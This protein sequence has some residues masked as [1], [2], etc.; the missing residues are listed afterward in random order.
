VSGARYYEF[1]IIDDAA[2]A[3]AFA[4]CAGISIASATF[5]HFVLGADTIDSA[6]VMGFSTAVVLAMFVAKYARAPRQVKEAANLQFR[7]RELIKL[8]LASI[9]ES[10][11]ALLIISV[12][13]KTS[14]AISY[15][16]TALDQV[17]SGQ[18]VSSYKIEIAKQTI[19][20]AL[21]KT[22]SA[23]SKTSLADAYTKLVLVE[24]YRRASRA[25]LV[26]E[27]NNVSGADHFPVSVVDPHDVVVENSYFDHC[28]LDLSGFAWLDT[29]FVRCSLR[30]TVK[31]LLFVNVSFV[32]C[33]IVFPPEEIGSALAVE[34]RTG[35]KSGVM[36]SS[37]ALA[38]LQNSTHAG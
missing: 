35:S 29:R 31:D 33:S 36:F 17:R 27:L 2:R 20:E 10:A 22:E 4:W 34:L 14:N 30:G 3:K 19:T 13:D 32:D 26:F 25:H 18:D 6:I 11:A 1:F 24:S 12:F 28:D 38:A 15:A 21:H 37:A 23:T 7:R 8:S 5:V 9:L 16:S